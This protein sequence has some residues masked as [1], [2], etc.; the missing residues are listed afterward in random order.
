MATVLELEASIGELKQEEKALQLKLQA[1]RGKIAAA[2][3]E[4]MSAR[5]TAET[6]A[7][8]TQQRARSRSRSSHAETRRVAGRTPRRTC[9]SSPSW[10]A[11]PPRRWQRPR[12]SRPAWQ[13]LCT[14]AG[15]ARIAGTVAVVGA[16]NT[17]SGPLVAAGPAGT[18]SW[19]SRGGRPTRAARVATAGPGNRS[20][21]AGESA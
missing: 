15:V 10:A 2:Q 20:S 12:R 5:K 17:R 21:E 9:R 16:S 14:R 6:S 3:L 19:A 11:A 8:A 7:P 18:A 13:S 4:L 1:V